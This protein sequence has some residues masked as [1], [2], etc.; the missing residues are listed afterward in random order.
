[1]PNEP[2]FTGGIKD[3]LSAFSTFALL[4][5]Y[6]SLS[7]NMEENR[8]LRQRE[9]SFQEA[10]AQDRQTQNDFTNVSM[11]SEGLLTGKVPR[12][13]AITEI[14]RIT[15]RRQTGS[16]VSTEQANQFEQV[17]KTALPTLSDP[18]TPAGERASILSS[19]QQTAM[20]HPAY[21]AVLLPYTSQLR[22]VT[23]LPTARELLKTLPEPVQKSIKLGSEMSPQEFITIYKDDKTRDALVKRGLVVAKSD[24]ER[25]LNESPELVS[26]GEIRETMV[27]WFNAGFGVG[28]KE[29]EVVKAGHGHAVLNRFIGEAAPVVEDVAKPLQDIV[30]RIKN[31]KELTLRLSK[32]P[33]QSITAFDPQGVI[34]GLSDKDTA[35]IQS[36]AGQANTVIADTERQKR[37]LD[38]QLRELRHNPAVTATDLVLLN[39][40]HK[41]TKQFL[42]LQAEP[43]RRFRTY[44]EDPTDA[45]YKKLSAVH[46]DVQHTV[47]NWALTRD[48]LLTEAEKH[49]RAIVAEA[50]FN[51]DVKQATHDAS[52]QLITELNRQGIAG[53]ET[54]KVRSVAAPIINNLNAKY[55]LKLDVNDV[56]KAT[57]GDPSITVKFP[58]EGER[59]DVAEAS[60][61]LQNF[62]MVEALYKPSY[63]G[64]IEGKVG[65]VAEATGAIGQQRADFYQATDNV[66][67]GLR[68][69][70]GGVAVTPTELKL[71]LGTIPNRGMSDPQFESSVRMN[72]IILG[73]DAQAKINVLK[74]LGFKTPEATA[75]KINEALNKAKA[76]VQ[77]GTSGVA[78]FN[79]DAFRQLKKQ[80]PDWTPEQIGREMAKGR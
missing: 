13:Y 46:T 50:T 63:V 42:D 27:P 47:D 67:R 48:K 24:L 71:L 45:N 33:V 17:V 23:L 16:P 19:L 80:H 56:L 14:N 70:F 10:A 34:P 40:D 8:Q 21:Q 9:L 52:A 58:G 68:K 69:F 73:G 32:H 39:E 65:S 55:N 41:R 2:G 30:G 26:D 72:K 22:D 60:N 15:T 43:Y 1:M 79:P 64:L 29:K 75:Q 35:F 31:P 62:N 57:K 7:E 77:A 36:L 44:V 74:E 51:R 38:S 61:I 59:K 20:S 18:T 49:E 78:S 5:Y 6:G 53:M 28:E 4:G 11:L 3:A 37:H 66:A 12:D 25:R 76:E 54:D